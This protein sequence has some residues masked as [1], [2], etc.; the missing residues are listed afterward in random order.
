MARTLR[1]IA[2]LVL[3]LVVI[4]AG[5]AQLER[6]RS[7]AEP[8]A[9]TLGG[10]PATFYEGGDAGLVIV[11]HGFAG[12]RQMMEAIALTLARAGHDV[13]AF[14]YPGHGRH[15][16][17]LSRDVER[18]TGTT[19]DLVEQ[20]IAVAEDAVR[21][22]GAEEISL[23]GHSMATDVIVR[24]ADRLEGVRAVAAISMYSDAVTATHPARLLIVSGEREG[25]LRDV[26]LDAVRGVG[27]GAEGETVGEDGILRR[28]VVAPRVGH[29]GV[30]W[31]GT[32]AREVAAWLG[33]ETQAV[34]IGPWI[35]ALL[36]AIVIAAYPLSTLLLPR[37]E[38][39]AA[40]PA[41]RAMLA[42]LVG[43]IAAVIAGATAL[44]ALGTAAFGALALSL[45]A[46]GVVTL[47][48]LRPRLSWSRGDAGAA[49]LMLAWGLG[50]FALALDRYGAAFVPTGPRLGLMVLLIPATLVFGVADR[51]LVHGRGLG[52]RLLLRLPVL[53]ALS[54]VIAL[55][56]DPMGLVFT[57]IPVLVLYWLVYGTMAGWMARR[58]GPAG[59]GLASGVILAWSLAASTPLFAA[60]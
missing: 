14:D 34:S 12:S 5:A 15:G 30:L 33:P 58:A 50:V 51:A 32:T 39:G 24:A 29:V 9:L 49:A 4:A 42:A 54:A 16:A 11:S 31:S 56:S 57:V 23:V 48:L 40:G 52:M 26:A 3:S 55:R 18:I 19:E 8:R 20:T 43:S 41:R 21:L 47:G 6:M 35:A 36:L 10:A 28:A 59:V 1:D 17:L 38:T 53:C 2:L 44:P 7:F 37:I 25:R 45:G 27:E 13:V 46:W 60:G 22:T